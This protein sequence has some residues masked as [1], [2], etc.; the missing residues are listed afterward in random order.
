[1]TRSSCFFSLKFYCIIILKSFETPILNEKRTALLACQVMANLRNR[2]L[3]TKYLI[4]LTV[5]M[6]LYYYFLKQNKFCSL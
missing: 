3:N 2:P 1:M 6:E 4:A 5:F